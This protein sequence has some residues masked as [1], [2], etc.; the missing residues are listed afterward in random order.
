MLG[1]VVAPD[2]VLIHFESH[3]EGSPALVLVH[4]W[5]CD[6]TYWKPQMA[7]LS[8]RYQVVAIDLAGHGQSGQER[9]QWTMP[10]FGADVAAVTTHLGLDR[11]VLVGH[12]MGGPVVAEAARQM[13]GRVLGVVGADT[14]RDLGVTFTDE[15][16]VKLLAPFQADFSSTSRRY[17]AEMFTLS[18]PAGLMTWIV[19]DMAAAPPAVGMGAMENN[20]RY[21]QELVR[22][23]RNLKVP[24]V[25]INSDYRPNDLEAAK[26]CGVD[27]RLMSG[28]GHFVMMEDPAT[29]NRMLEEA[30]REFTRAGARV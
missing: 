11:V 25:A 1:T 24:V 15:E 9:R 13:P 28:T 30:V 12:S 23:L 6:R 22:T 16:I 19:E 26:K 5:C 14:F 20:R 17:V 2:G 7:P 29:F 10:A 18:S 27:I 4:G 21:R 8:Q 3:G